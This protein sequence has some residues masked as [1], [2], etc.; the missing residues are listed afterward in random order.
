M[1]STLFRIRKGIFCSLQFDRLIWLFY[2]FDLHLVFTFSSVIHKSIE[3]EVAVWNCKLDSVNTGSTN[4]KQ[5]NDKG[6]RFWW[7]KVWRSVGVI[8]V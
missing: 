4:K 6:K 3:F 2:L 7:D 8:L 1:I 5:I